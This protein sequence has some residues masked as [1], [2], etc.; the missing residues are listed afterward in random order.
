MALCLVFTFALGASAHTT[1][2]LHKVHPQSTGG[3][4]GRFYNSSRN[5]ISASACINFD[6]WTEELQADAYITFRPNFS[7][8][9]ISACYVY[10]LIISNHGQYPGAFLQ[11]NCVVAASNSATDAYFGVLRTTAWSYGDY[12]NTIVNVKMTYS[13]NTVSV[14]NLAQSQR[15]Y[16]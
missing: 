16:L 3:G 15:I 5:D 8:G 2:A 13:S 1:P 12:A 14:V 11:Q 10:I 4:C 9:S 7:L 6:G